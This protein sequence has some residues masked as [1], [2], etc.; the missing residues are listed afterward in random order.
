MLLRT[1]HLFFIFFLLKFVLCTTVIA[2]DVLLS[3]SRNCTLRKSFSMSRRKYGSRPRWKASCAYACV[4]FRLVTAQIHPDA[5]TTHGG[6]V[7]SIMWKKHSSDC[8]ADWEIK[9]E[10]NEEHGLGLQQFVNLPSAKH[11][12]SAS[13]QLIS[14]FLP[15]FK[16]ITL[17]AF[18]FETECDYWISLNQ[19]VWWG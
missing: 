14:L 2:N 6:F 19:F 15:P 9:S 3:I 1:T 17:F 11:I 12:F 4:M 16:C 10:V 8:N 7:I 5:I 13:S 18:S